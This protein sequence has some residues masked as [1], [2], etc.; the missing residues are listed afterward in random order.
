MANKSYGWVGELHWQ[1]IKDLPWP[2]RISKI[3]YLM[4]YFNLSLMDNYLSRD[5]PYQGSLPGGM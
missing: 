2:L 4:D 5:S 1:T 3:G